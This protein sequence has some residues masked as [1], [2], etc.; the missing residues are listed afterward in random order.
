MASRD[1][2]ARA[3]LLALARGIATQRRVTILYRDAAGERTGRALDPFAL[4]WRRG[5]WLLAAHCHR[6]RAFRLFRVDRMLRVQVLTDS[7][8]RAIAPPGF[9]LR[10]FSSI[11]YLESGTDEPVLATIRLEHRLKRLARVLFPTALLEPCSNA[12]TLCHIRTTALQEL[13]ALIASLGPGVEIV[14]PTEAH[15]VVYR[16]P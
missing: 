6:R 13:A 8:A 11:G 12:G 3:R 2:G 15:G 10:F 16:P 9:E 1:A 5:D 7:S 14:H 4:S